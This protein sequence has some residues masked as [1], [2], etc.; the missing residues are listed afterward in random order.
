M[1]VYLFMYKHLL[2]LSIHLKTTSKPNFFEGSESLP[3]KLW[4]VRSMNVCLFLRQKSTPPPLSLSTV[5]YIREVTSIENLASTNFIVFQVNPTKKI[6]P[7]TTKSIQKSFFKMSNN[8]LNKKKLNTPF[9]RSLL[10]FSCNGLTFKR[11]A[12]SNSP[13]QITVISKFHSGTSCH[14]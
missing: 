14:K 12:A 8:F 7:I 4:Y 5:N 6:P 10:E 11:C 3:F 13:W 1:Q 9:L 2:L